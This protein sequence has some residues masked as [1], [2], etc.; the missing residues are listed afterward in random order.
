MKT[1]RKRKFKGVK[2]SSPV[3]PVQANTPIESILDTS[4]EDTKVD[5]DALDQHPLKVGSSIIVQY[6]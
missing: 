1:Q 2:A 6:R 3:P 4:T 5:V